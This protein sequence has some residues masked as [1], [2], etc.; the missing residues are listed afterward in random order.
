MVEQKS[1]KLWIS[2]N[3]RKFERKASFIIVDNYVMQSILYKKYKIVWSKSSHM[4]T[5]IN[6]TKS[7]NVI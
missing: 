2:K 4:T 3:T 1:K 7:N 5:N 6:K